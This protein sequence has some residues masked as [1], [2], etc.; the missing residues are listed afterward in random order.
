MNTIKKLSRAQQETLLPLAIAYNNA[1]AQQD[2]FVNYL[3][4]ELGCPVPDWQITDIEEGFVN[5]RASKKA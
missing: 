3:R 5:M 2:A 1:K 4:A